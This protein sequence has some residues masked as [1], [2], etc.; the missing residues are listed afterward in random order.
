M[1]IT[2][3]VIVT[4]LL[5]LGACA[6]SP[7]YVAADGAYDHGYSSRKI[8]ENRYRVNFNGNRHTNFQ[9]TRDYALLRAAELTLAKD[10]E[11]F[12]VIDRESATT[13]TKSTEPQI[14]FAHQR[15]YYVESNCGLLGCTRSTRPAMTNYAQISTGAHRT[16]T[17][18][19]HSIEILIGKGEMPENGHYYDAESVVSSIY[20]TL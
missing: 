1:L 6:S 4:A 13:E 20:S 3:I 11:W 17:T 9:D 2:R 5:T 16:R 18:H 12:Q 7:Q 10:H 15:A 8:A 14:G 19:S